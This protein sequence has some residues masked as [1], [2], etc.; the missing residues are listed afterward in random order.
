VAR[1]SRFAHGKAKIDDGGNYDGVRN[2][3]EALDE[4]CVPSVFLPW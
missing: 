4:S 1:Q 2:H 3:G